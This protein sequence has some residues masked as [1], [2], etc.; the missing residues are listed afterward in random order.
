[1]KIV[2]TAPVDSVPQRSAPDVPLQG[3]RI[4]LVDDESD[5]RTTLAQVLAAQGAEVRVCDSAAGARIAL[6]D[7]RPDLIISDIGMPHESG[8]DLMKSIRALPKDAGGS[9]PA[10]ALTGYSQETLREATLSAGY[11]RHVAKPVE[12]SDLVAL[13]RTLLANA[14]PGG[15]D[16]DGVRR[17]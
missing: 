9:V 3:I 11:D 10:I 8:L 12:P 4:L 17:I 5:G 1:V 14:P 13:A 15:G 2:P 7:L 6:H 16:P